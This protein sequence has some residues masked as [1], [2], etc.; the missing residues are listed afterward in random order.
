MRLVAL[1]GRGM[2]WP[3]IA[4]SSRPF[5]DGLRSNMHRS[6]AVRAR[7]A[8]DASAAHSAHPQRRSLPRRDRRRRIR[9][10]LHDAAAPFG[11]PPPGRSALDQLKAQR[12]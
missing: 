10:G 9:R 7:Q 8:P 2:E 1:R 5:A 6:S 11:D 4:A 12:A 3:A